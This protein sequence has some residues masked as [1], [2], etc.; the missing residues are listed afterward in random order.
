MDQR[1]AADRRLALAD[2]P[3]EHE[4]NDY[5]YVYYSMDVLGAANTRSSFINSHNHHMQRRIRLWLTSLHPAPG[6]TH[7]QC[8]SRRVLNDNRIFQ[9]SRPS[10]E[11]R[12]DKLP[13]HQVPSHTTHDARVTCRSLLEY[14]YEY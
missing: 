1:Y 12:S 9:F 13:L 14:D 11:R 7:S 6:M 10:P 3:Q 5:V 8:L 2:T 4:A